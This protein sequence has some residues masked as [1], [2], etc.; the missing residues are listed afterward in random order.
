MAGDGRLLVNFAALQQATADINKAIASLQQQL[1][2]LEKHAA[3]LVETWQGNAKEAYHVRQN[4]WRRSADD[5][6]QI[7]QNIKAAVERSTEDY[8]QTERAAT[9]RFS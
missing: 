4:Q 2:Q 9:Q 7:L 6:T 1:D 5:L 3:P 8:V